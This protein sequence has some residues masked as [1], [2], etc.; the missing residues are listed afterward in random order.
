MV[1]K[2]QR[3]KVH[4]ARTSVHHRRLGVHVEG[5]GGSPRTEPYRRMYVM[6]SDPR[7]NDGDKTHRKNKGGEKQTTVPDVFRSGQILDENFPLP[8]GI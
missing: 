2:N 5:Q 7:G 6:H 8:R 1:E 4:L 3:S